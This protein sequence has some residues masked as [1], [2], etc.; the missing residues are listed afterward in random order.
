VWPAC[1]LTNGVPRGEQPAGRGPGVG[2]AGV[3]L[4]LPLTGSGTRDTA[5]SSGD[6]AAAGEGGTVK[7]IVTEGCSEGMEIERLVVATP[8]SGAVSDPHWN[9]EEVPGDTIGVVR[10]RVKYPPASNETGNFGTLS[11]KQYQ[12]VIE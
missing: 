3:T 2:S 11:Y 1:A 8:L 5:N 12:R 7:L 6:V 9:L 10:V 4:E